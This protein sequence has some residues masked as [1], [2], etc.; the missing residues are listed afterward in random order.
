M[1]KE[2]EFYQQKQGELANDGF[3]FFSI[4]QPFV[5]L[6]LYALIVRDSMIDLESYTLGVFKFFIK[7]LT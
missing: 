2:N 3:S 7:R 6:V 1:L 5:L 4:V